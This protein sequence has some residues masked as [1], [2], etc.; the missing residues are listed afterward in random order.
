MIQV[1]RGPKY[2]IFTV[3]V[4]VQMFSHYKQTNNNKTNKKMLQRI[5]YVLWE[6]LD[7]EM[8]NKVGV[9]A[10][11]VG[12]NTGPKWILE[13]SMP[14]QFFL[15]CVICGG[16]M[17]IYVFFLHILINADFILLFQFEGG[18]YATALVLDAAYKLADTAKKAP[19][20]AE[21]GSYMLNFV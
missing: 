20:I 6:F 21:V 13:K 5:L 11:G 9:L 14:T 7:C 18:L 17:Y 12:L 15:G 3:S 16:C 10:L 4:H 1:R 2:H 19:T 8:G